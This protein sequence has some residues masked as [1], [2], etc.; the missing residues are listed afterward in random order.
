MTTATATAVDLH[1]HLWTPSLLTALAARST[2]PFVRRDVGAWRLV[3]DGEPDSLVPA[4]DVDARARLVAADGLDLGIVALSTA[5]GIESLPAADARPLLDAYAYGNA[6][7]PDALR[8]W[9]AVSLTGNVDETA[10]ELAQRLP[11]GGDARSPQGRV[12][13]S[14]AGGRSIRQTSAPA[15]PIGLCLPAAALASPVAVD[16]LG[17]LLAVLADAGAPLF[18]HPGP[19]A[20]PAGAPAWWPALTDYVAQLQ[21][22]WLALTTTGRTAHPT[23]R[24]VFAALAGLAPLHHERLTARGGSDAALRDALLFYETSSYGPRALRAMADTVGLSQLVHGSDRPV[25][26]P[27][28]DAVAAGLGDS[29]WSTLTIANLA[30]LFAPVPTPL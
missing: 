22:A 24:I 11:A 15:Q 1:Q 8:S 16:A 9:A 23:L 19:A 29:A 7:L 30:R 14:T 18:V 20:A 5:L 26:T 27:A 17:P 10:A 21:A 4:D 3:L 25:V 6:D 28:P 2:P 12:A 13:D